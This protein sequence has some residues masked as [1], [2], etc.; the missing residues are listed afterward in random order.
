MPVQLGRWPDEAGDRGYR[1][2]DRVLDFAGDPVLHDGVWRIL[3]VSNGGDTAGEISSPIAGAWKISVKVIVANLGDYPRRRS[4]MSR[5]IFRPVPSSISTIALTDASYRWTR[6]SLVRDRVVGAVRAGRRAPVY[7]ARRLDSPAAHLSSSRLDGA[8]DETRERTPPHHG[9]CRTRPG[10]SRF[11]RRRARHAA[12]QEERQPG[13]SR[14]R[15][16]C[17]MRMRR[18]GPART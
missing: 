8:R 17:S 3:N 11:L 1:I 18:G 9:H 2:Y 16:T 10:E 15:I 5:Q 12:R 13:R 4:W 14:E 7:R 6:E